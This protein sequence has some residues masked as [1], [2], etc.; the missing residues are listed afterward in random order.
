MLEAPPT[1]KSRTFK[2]SIVDYVE[3]RSLKGT[4]GLNSHWLKTETKICEVSFQKHYTL[5]KLKQQFIHSTKTTN[6]RVLSEYFITASHI[7]AIVS[8][9]H[10]NNTISRSMSFLSFFHKLHNSWTTPNTLVQLF[11]FVKPDV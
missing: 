5:K 7:I 4:V 3:L 11:W 1:V 10:I 6:E 8:W 9:K 2:G